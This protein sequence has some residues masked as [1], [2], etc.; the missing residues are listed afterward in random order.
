MLRPDEGGGEDEGDYFVLKPR[1]SGFFHTSLELL[2]EHL[3]VQTLI[4]TGVAGN[5]CVLFT[6][7]DAYLRGYDVVVP[8]DGLADEDGADTQR[9]LE[10][11]RK[12]LKAQTPRLADVDLEAL[13]GGA[14][15]RADA[16]GG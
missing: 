9:A 12:V 2:L 15:G 10:Q 6:A 8:E 11:M 14:R 16:S 3:G 13:S 5:N 7:N 1:H 4:V